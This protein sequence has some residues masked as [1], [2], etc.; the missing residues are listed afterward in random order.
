MDPITPDR[1]IRFAYLEA[2]RRKRG[3]RECREWGVGL[4]REIVGQMA[5]VVAVNDALDPG[6]SHRMEA[7]R[8]ASDILAS[9]CRACGKCRLARE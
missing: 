5:A 3:T 2:R 8:Q 9:H 1:I 6:L 7:T 4:M